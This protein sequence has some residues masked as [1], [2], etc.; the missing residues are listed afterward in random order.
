MWLRRVSLSS[1]LLLVL[2]SAIA[3]AKPTP[4]FDQSLVQNLGWQKGGVQG[5]FKLLEQLNLSTEQTQKLKAIYSQYKEE[6]SQ[7]KKTLRQTTKQLR[8]LMVSTASTEEIRAQ[9]QQVE[10]VRQQLETASFE[11]MLAM[12]EVLTPAQRAQ[13]AQLMEQQ[14]KTFYSRMANQRGQ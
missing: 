4:V 7:R 12:R 6:I 1:V 11:S 2:G 3:I 10:M 9:Y 14:E 5:E 8:T 13:F